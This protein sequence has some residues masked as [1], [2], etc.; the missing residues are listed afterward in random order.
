[1]RMRVKRT[2]RMRGLC[3]RRSARAVRCALEAIEPQISLSKS[4]WLQIH[5]ATTPRVQAFFVILS[6]FTR[7]DHWISSRLIRALADKTSF[8]FFLSVYPTRKLPDVRLYR[9]AKREPSSLFL[10]NYRR[11]V[12][13]TSIC[14]AR[15]GRGGRR[16]SHAASTALSISYY[17]HLVR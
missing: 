5:H 10:L 12:L 14:L 1:M 16:T 9:I 7:F 3:G 4:L 8:A 15:A 17:T 2:K 13:N 6:P 11:V